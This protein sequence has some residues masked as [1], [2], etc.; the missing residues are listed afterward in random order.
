MSN[1][2]VPTGFGASRDEMRGEERRGEERRVQ[3]IEQCLQ[4]RTCWYLV[5]TS[6]GQEQTMAVI[7]AVFPGS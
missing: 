1:S 3:E 5:L 7:K 4:Y 2:Q 6:V